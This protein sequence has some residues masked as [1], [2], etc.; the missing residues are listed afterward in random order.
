M[1]AERR[2][3]MRNRVVVL[4]AV[5]AFLLGAVGLAVVVARSDDDSLPK[6]P[7][8]SAGGGERAAADVASL[9]APAMPIVYRFEGESAEVPDAAPAYRLERSDVRTAVVA[10][11]DA[12]GVRGDVEQRGGSWVVRGEERGVVVHDAPGLP[13]YQGPG[14]SC[15]DQSV[16]SDDKEGVASCVVTGEATARAAPDA[17]VESGHPPAPGFCPP[18]PPNA[19]CA[20]CGAPTRPAD[21]PST[22]EA[23]PRFRE[24]FERL[25]TGGEPTVTDNVLTLDALVRPTVHGLPTIGYEHGLTMGPK[26]EIVGGYGSLGRPQKLGDYPLTSVD[27]AVERLQTGFSVGPRTLSAQVEQVGPDGAGVQEVVLTGVKL[28][29]QSVEGHLVPAFLFDVADGD[30]PAV[31]AVVDRLL[32]DIAPA[33]DPVP[34]GSSGCGVSVSGVGADRGNEPVNEPLTV[35]V[36]GPNTAKVGEEVVFEVTATDPDAEIIESGCGGPNVSYG[37]EE[38][39]VHADCMPACAAPLKDGSPGKFGRAFRHTY[40]KPGTYSARFTFRSAFCTKGSSSGEG[41]HTVTVK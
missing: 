37:D 8:A 26:G 5:L 11:A 23:L 1:D 18:C 35:E 30:G 32:D 27:E 40:E 12:L 7:L 9:S 20:P 36:C 10:L 24:V 21:L 34:E 16:S 22:A 15:P 17:P 3:D 31:P 6:L 14:S 41:T 25:G 39:G 4:A 2:T 33:P 19:D 29:L 28:G 38:G 13:W